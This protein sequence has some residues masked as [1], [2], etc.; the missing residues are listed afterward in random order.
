MFLGNP[1]NAEAR[2]SKSEELYLWCSS[3]EEDGGGVNWILIV[4]LITRI[5]ALTGEKETS[6]A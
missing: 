5:Q 3:W 2:K 4:E 1:I 6:R